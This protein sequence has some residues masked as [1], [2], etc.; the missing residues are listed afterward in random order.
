MPPNM[1]AQA[2]AVYLFTVNLIGMG[3]GPTAV[4]WITDN[5]FGNPADVGWSFLLFAV[6]AHIGAFAL[7]RISAKN[8]DTATQR[9]TRETAAL[10]PAPQPALAR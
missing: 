3:I 6:A 5:V 4:G 10:S 2:S 8:Y 9:L 7:L 1:R